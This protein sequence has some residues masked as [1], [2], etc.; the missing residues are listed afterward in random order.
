MLFG[1]HH[2]DGDGGAGGRQGGDASEEPQ[3]GIGAPTGLR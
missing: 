1:H 3:G 2:T